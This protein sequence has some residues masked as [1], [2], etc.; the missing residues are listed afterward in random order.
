MHDWNV[1]QTTI[2]LTEGWNLI[3]P[4]LA[5]Y[6][7][8][9]AQD[10]AGSIINCTHV[11]YWNNTQQNFTLYTTG[12]NG[13]DFDVKTGVGY[14]VYVTSNSI[15]TLQG[16]I[17]VNATMQLKIGWNSI[18]R[19]NETGITASELA[20]TI[21]NCTVVA[22]WNNTLSRFII[23]PV[24]TLLSDFVIRQNI[25]YLVWVSSDE[26]WVNK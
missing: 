10:L 16:D 14:M 20:A 17:F 7:I 25:G 26:T 13:N 22:Y 12:V 6:T 8:F 4:S 3:T 11:T 1:S 9:T 23:H 5:P 18:G 15:L 21:T 2:D 24:N 19:F